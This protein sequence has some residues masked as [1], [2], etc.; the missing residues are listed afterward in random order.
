MLVTTTVTAS[1]VA[2]GPVQQLEAIESTA[3]L[4]ARASDAAYNLDYAEG[5]ELAREA[6][7]REP[8]NSAAHRTLAS[9]IWQQILF[10][11]GTVTLD[12]YMSG[13][14]G[15][16]KHLPEPSEALEREFAEAVARARE[17]A[18]AQLEQDGNDDSVVAHY[19]AGAVYGL[20]ASYKA[21]VDGSLGGA[22]RTAK[23]AFDAQE[24][25]LK[26]DP[27]H[28]QAATVVGTYRYVVSALGLPSR[29]LAYIVGFG[30]GKERGIALLEGAA[31][32]PD[33]RTEAGLALMLIYTREGRHDEAHQVALSL[34]GHHPRN[35]LLVLEAGASAIRAGRAEEAEAILARGLAGFLRDSRP[36]SPGEHAVWLFKRGVAR[37]NQGHL[38]TAEEDFRA[39]LDAGPVTWM[40]GR[41]RAGFG[42]LADLAG[43]RETAL[44]E[45]E[46]ARSICKQFG[47]RRCEDE[48]KQ[49]Q[50]RPF[51]MGDRAVQ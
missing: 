38:D 48:V 15:A 30:G 37:M 43:D 12:H 1:T 51:V 26:L 31:D 11:R 9:V 6:V 41:I 50:R 18:E 44:A 24:R 20:E 16:Q 19:N 14:D 7:Q 36:K 3:S 25:V 39:A 8:E 42:K 32:H 35:R 10:E 40:G 49:L 29:W 27:D 22:F 28:A 45:Y 33:A 17:I 47:D 23:R 34:G 13:M 4:L 2:R 5:L 21:S 46:Q